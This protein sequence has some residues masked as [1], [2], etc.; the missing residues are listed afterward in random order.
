MYFR[1][2]TFDEQYIEITSHWL[3]EELPS[4]GRLRFDYVD[5][6]VTEP[7]NTF[8]RSALSSIPTASSRLLT[9]SC[10]SQLYSSLY[11]Q[12]FVQQQ[13]L[14]LHPIL[15]YQTIS[16]TASAT[17]GVSIYNGVYKQCYEY[18]LLAYRHT[19][20]NNF[21]QPTITAT[22]TSTSAMGPVVEAAI[23]DGKRSPSH[24][25][26][27]KPPAG[28]LHKSISAPVLAPLPTNHHQT[29]TAPSHGHHH[30]HHHNHH[31]QES[32]NDQH[33]LIKI[34]HSILPAQNIAWSTY[35]N[36]LVKQE[37]YS[38]LL[39]AQ[40]LGDKQVYT[41]SSKLTKQLKLSPKNLCILH[42]SS[43]NNGSSGRN[44][45]KRSS[46]TDVN[47]KKG[48]VLNIMLKN[49]PTP[50]TTNSGGIG[51][52]N[53]SSKSKK[54]KNKNVME[55]HAE[56]VQEDDYDD[57]ALRNG[58]DDEEEDEEDEEESYEDLS[59]WNRENIREKILQD[60][61]A[62]RLQKQHAGNSGENPRNLRMISKESFFKLQDL[63]NNL[64]T[65]SRAAF[66][67]QNHTLV[68]NDN[69]GLNATSSKTTVG[70]TSNG[71]PG[72]PKAGSM[73]AVATQTVNGFGQVV[74]I[75]QQ[76]ESQMRLQYQDLLQTC[77]QAYWHWYQDGMNKQCQQLFAD[78]VKQLAQHHQYHF[79]S[80]K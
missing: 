55:S 41:Q 79:T 47:G 6:S 70:M 53:K 34:P 73:A 31:A 75:Q 11:N 60:I 1:N 80:D 63:T 35:Q 71:K 65:G 39:I 8:L 78:I 10:L 64:D 58:S 77:Y 15:H 33:S 67:L 13:K 23:P 48:S 27:H 62:A 46:S 12:L 52:K 5:I 72:T 2:A 16:N 66:V 4:R 61:K 3:A 14:S 50:T 59:Q 51:N 28:S 9:Q 43:I 54:N 32:H 7:S 25:G 69:N 68:P 76:Y 56:G 26:A 37:Q 29:S 24:G 44:K 57:F 21:P 42:A 38:D 45:G 36:M 18:A 49:Y 20:T 74:N 30:G 19:H 22:A 17:G 40:C